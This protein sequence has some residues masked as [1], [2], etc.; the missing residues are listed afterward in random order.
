M[1]TTFIILDALIALQTAI[2]IA[3]AIVLLV[4]L[5]RA[6]SASHAVRQSVNDL[7]PRV[8]EILERVNEFVK[9][10]QPVGGRAADISGDIKVMV[11]SARGSVAAMTDVVN[12]VSTRV[13][14]QAER[15]DAVFTENLNKFERLSD[16]VS[17]NLL[18][19]MAEI[20]ALLRGGYAAAKYLRRQKA[21][22][23]TGGDGH[24]EETPI[25]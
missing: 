3:S 4:V 1:L 6:I 7:L 8:N 10:S 19:P 2:I 21:S 22:A 11:E 17:E 24:E 16:T 14:N 20:S 9:A 25:I 15:V 13:K 5:R 18:A 12:D 23:P